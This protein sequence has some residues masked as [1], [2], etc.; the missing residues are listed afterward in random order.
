MK[1]RGFNERSDSNY[2]RLLNPENG[3]CVIGESGD[4]IGRG[5]RTSVYFDDEA[6]HLE[7]AERDRGGLD[8]DDRRWHRHLF[9]EDRVTV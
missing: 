2:M 1:P 8:R 5:G 6:A 3:A 7:H 9:T 4:N